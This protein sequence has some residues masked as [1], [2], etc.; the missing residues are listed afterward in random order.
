MITALS[1]QR[2]WICARYELA[3]IRLL[4]LWLMLVASAVVAS[5]LL[6]QFYR[7]TANAQIGRAENDVVRGCR[8]ITDRYTFFVAGRRGVGANDINDTLKSQLNAV[9][10]NI[11]TLI[12]FRKD[13]VDTSK[14]NS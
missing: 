5:Y 11:S 10:Q 7:Q 12:A 2:T 13:S 14:L 6:W 4:A 8:N 3:A 1:V 9:V